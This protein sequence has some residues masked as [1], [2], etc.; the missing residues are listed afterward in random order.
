M[1]LKMSIYFIIF[2]DRTGLSFNIE[3][4]SGELYFKE[5]PDF[6][7]KS[8]YDLVINATSQPLPF[9]NFSN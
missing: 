4:N 1:K 2:Q 9:E 7:V 6:E 5:I 8:S 3:N